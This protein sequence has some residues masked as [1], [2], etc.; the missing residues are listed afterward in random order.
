MNKI[1]SHATE[2]L[3]RLCELFKVQPNVRALITV[4]CRP[5]QAFEEVLYQVL[6]ERTVDLAV[7][8]Q[9]DMLG[10]IVGQPRGGLVDDDYRRYIRARIRV[11]RSSGTIDELIVIARLI[12]NDEDATIWLEPSY[13]AACVMHIQGI[14]VDDA[15][16]TALVVFLR[17]AATGGVRVV[18][19]WSTV[20]PEDT[21]TWDS[22]VWDD[23]DQW[24]GSFE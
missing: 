1:E 3:D 24:A 13:P 21:F 11:N 19:E 15:I 10:V 14:P 7:G 9:L 20:A 22:S 4:W 12:V 16:A 23:T 8:V 5:V 17:A 6:T 18:L 2:A